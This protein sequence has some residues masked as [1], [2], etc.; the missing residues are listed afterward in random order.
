MLRFTLL[1]EIVSDDKT[2]LLTENRQVEDYFRLV[3]ESYKDAYWDSDSLE[4]IKAFSDA[5]RVGDYGVASPYRE[6]CIT[7]LSTECKMGLLILFCKQKQSKKVIVNLEIAD[8]KIWNWLAARM[9]YTVYMR[10][11]DLNGDSTHLEKC[12][13]E[14]RNKVKHPE[15]D[16]TCRSDRYSTKDLVEGDEWISWKYFMSKEGEDRIWRAYEKSRK[17][18]GKV[19]RFPL[20]M[21]LMDF[22]TQFPNGLTYFEKMDEEKRNIWKEFTVINYCSC[23]PVNILNQKDS[24][25]CWLETCAMAKDKVEYFGDICIGNSPKFCE[26]LFNDILNKEDFSDAGKMVWCGDLYDAWFVLIVNSEPYCQLKDYPQKS[27]LG[28]EINKKE[29]TITIYDKRQ[30]AERFHMLFAMTN[31]PI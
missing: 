22:I 24:L 14:Y 31:W 4:F 28:I 21:N 16:P 5:K 3:L 7:C 25:E 10:I 17:N 6:S 11:E 18:L 23:I 13:F 26:A 2:V 12:E 20:E 15:H 27:L 9:D 1:D 8:I 19:I 29:K 30:A